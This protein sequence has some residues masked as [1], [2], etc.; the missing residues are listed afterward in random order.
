MLDA[1]CGIGLAFS[2]LEQYFQPKTIVGVDIDKK[3]IEIAAKSA[4]QRECQVILEASPVVDFN[5]AAQSFDMIFCHQLLHHTE[6]QEGAVQQFH[7]LLVP[8]GV[9]LIAESCRPFIRSL[10]VRLLFRHPMEAQKSATE[11]VDLVKSMGFGVSG[12]DIRAS[13]PWWSRWDFGLVEKFGIA[14]RR[15]S[16]TTEILIVARKPTAQGC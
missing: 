13:T 12:Q 3:L 9:L 15:S 7:R 1:G 10:P 8:G 16:Q 4:Q 14:G 6:D 5:F 2:L 11:Y